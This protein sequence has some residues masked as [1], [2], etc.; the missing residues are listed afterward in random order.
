MPPNDSH[1]EREST[2]FE[3][4]LSQVP[5][6]ASPSWSEVCA[7]RPNF[8]RGLRPFL[9]RMISRTTSSTPPGSPRSVS[10]TPILGMLVLTQQ[11]T[12]TGRFPGRPASDPVD[13]TE[14]LERGSTVHYF[15]DY[16]I[17]K[18]IG[19]GGM[20]V[21]YK[22]KQVSLNRRVALKLNL[23]A[24]VLADEDDL[25]RFQNQAEAVAQLDH[26]GMFRFTKWGGTKAIAI[27][28]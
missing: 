9:P 14:I 3:E 13:P 19:Q 1:H 20:G 16:E 28:R 23:K 25:R 15:G 18:K 22:A 24:G 2:I 11:S 26:P 17:Q 12:I 6:E 8:A 10:W 4:M 5:E 21:V 7:G 27:S